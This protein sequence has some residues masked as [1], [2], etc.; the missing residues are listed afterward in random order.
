MDIHLIDEVLDLVAYTERTLSQPGAN[1]LLAGRAGTGRKAATQL[2]A[3]LLNMDFCTPSIGRDYCMKEFK[4]D[5]KEVLQK[6]GIE[7]TRTCLFVEDH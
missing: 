7:G 2:V 6:A 5:L 1:L 3:H 4:R